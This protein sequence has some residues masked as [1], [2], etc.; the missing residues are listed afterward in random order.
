[1]AIIIKKGKDPSGKI[2]PDK[3]VVS[4]KGNIYFVNKR[5]AMYPGPYTYPGPNTY[6]GR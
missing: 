3:L 5:T 6:P 1:M 4:H 2:S